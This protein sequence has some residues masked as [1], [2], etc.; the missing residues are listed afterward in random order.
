[1]IERL[2]NPNMRAVTHGSAGSMTVS[3]AMVVRNYACECHVAIYC[4][5]K[6]T[7]LE[8]FCICYKAGAV[9]DKTYEK[10]R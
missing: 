9:Q 10:E 3:F 2:Q 4:H 8:P 6:R 5:W 1:M 7:I